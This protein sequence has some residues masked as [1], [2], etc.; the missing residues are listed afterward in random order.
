[1][2]K[3]KNGPSL[4]KSS[5]VRQ[6]R[7]FGFALLCFFASAAVAFADGGVVLAEQTSGPYH[8]TLFGSPSPL[9][10]G[11]ADISVFLQDAK[12]GEP[13]LDPSVTVQLQA[14]S[15]AARDAW[16]PPC[17]S[18]KSDTRPVSATHANAQNKLLYAANLLVAS[19]GPHEIQV[20]IGKENTAAL[21]AKINIEP[22]FPPV[23]AYWAYLAFPPLAIAGFAL[24]QRLRRRR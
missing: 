20:R 6:R 15:G 14:T 17:C 16:L 19:S 12:T 3:I 23:T 18:M 10:A 13:I 24:N 5:A 4:A 21:R 22:P 11:A 8:I 2:E 7:F 1:M 9:R